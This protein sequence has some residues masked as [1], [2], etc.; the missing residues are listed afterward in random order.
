M[1]A[2]QVETAAKF[3]SAENVTVIGIALF[4]IVILLYIIKVLF[5]SW[6]KE[7]EHSRE[8]DQANLK[9]F[10]GLANHLGLV[11]TKIG[12]VH[13]KVVDGHTKIEELRT[14][15]VASLSKK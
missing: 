13:G 9:V 8:S 15:I 3:L 6:Q 12:D 10:I 7:L 1:I 5:N 11:D 2:L 4:M 14:L